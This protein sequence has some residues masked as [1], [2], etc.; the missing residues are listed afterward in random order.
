MDQVVVNN[1][2]RLLAR[3]EEDKLERLSVVTKKRPKV[4]KPGKSGKGAKVER[5]VEDDKF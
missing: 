4:L 2:D 3:K 1:L 5:D